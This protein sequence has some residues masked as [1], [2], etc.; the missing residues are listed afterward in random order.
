MS[1]KVSFL[2]SFPAV[3]SAIK[4]TGDA[5]GMR[6]TLE[7]PESEMAEAVKLMLYRQVV[8]RVTVEEDKQ[9]I[10][11][12]TTDSNNNAIQK[13]TKRKSEWSATEK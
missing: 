5:S 2:A 12:L 6:I 11:C 1:E 4:V 10:H 7:I 9:S 8:L 3:Q 13:G